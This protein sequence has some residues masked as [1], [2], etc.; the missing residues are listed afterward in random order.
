MVQS[1]DSDELHQ[2]RGRLEGPITQVAGDVV[3]LPAPEGSGVS[4]G[5][6]VVLPEQRE[7]LLED[8]APGQGLLAAKDVL[9]SVDAEAQALA[10]KPRSEAAGDAA[11]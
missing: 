5:T 9:K 2:S 6:D 7:D 11:P 3:L 1:P 8:L 10:T 4:L